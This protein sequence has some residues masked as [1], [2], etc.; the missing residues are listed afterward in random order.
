MN[1]PAV[2]LRVLALPLLLVG[3]AVATAACGG[4][5]GDED[6][7]EGAGPLPDAATLTGTAADRM[8]ALESFHF[9][10]SHEAGTTPITAGLQMERAEGDSKT[11]DRLTAD[12]D[13][14]V[15]QLGNAEIDVKV[16]WVREIARMTNPFDRTRWM[17]VPGDALQGLFDPGA[18]TVAALRAA[19]GHTVAGEETIGGV[20]CWVVTAV[21]DGE[22]LKAFADV[23]EA[24][25]TVALTLWI[26]EQ[27]NRVHRV[28]L[29]GPMGA[30]DTPGV[31]RVIDL[32]RFDEPVEIELPPE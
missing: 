18:G 19:T 22:A 29:D 27:D 32:T 25:Y 21:V 28:R 1:P 15:P 30:D 26:G 11:P 12:V 3:L 16:I 7:G 17:E 31:I 23:A 9:V 6:T 2:F 8:E 4:G 5:G 13:A 14:L 10:V 20:P 24:G